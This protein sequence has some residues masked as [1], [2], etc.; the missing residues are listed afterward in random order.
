MRRLLLIPLISLALASMGCGGGGGGNASVATPRTTA[1]AFSPASLAASYVGNGQSPTGQYVPIT[2]TITDLPAGS[3]YPL[4]TEDQPIL[5]GTTLTWALVGANTYNA[6]LSLN[7]FLAPGTYRG[8][9]SL[10]LAKD[11]G[12]TSFY[13]TTGGVLP[14]VLTVQRGISITAWINGAL[15]DPTNLNTVEG[16][17]VELQ[18]DQPVNLST[19]TS[20]AFVTYMSTGLPNS[21]KF[22]VHYGQST[23]GGLGVYQ[24]TFYSLSTPPVQRDIAVKVQG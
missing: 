5:E 20:G 15:A 7:R 19:A 13:P 23:P 9:L 10:K 24:L 1:I 21:V 16:D 18:A 6:T 8:N 22:T 12:G 17:V 11:P 4:L 2:A 14:Y 3:V